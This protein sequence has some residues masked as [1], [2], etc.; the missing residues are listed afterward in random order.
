MTSI[1]FV[2][3]ANMLRSASAEYLARWLM[4][5]DS[6]NATDG[7]E[8]TSAGV[9]VLP[10]QPIYDDAAA[11]LSTRGIDASAHRARQLIGRMMPRATLILTFDSAQRSWALRESPGGIR[12]VLTIRRAANLLGAA[13]EPMPDGPSAGQ[14][15]TGRA[16]RR[17]GR[18]GL[19]SLLVD[20]APYGPDDDFADPVG[21]G[22][23]AVATAV[24]QIEELLRTILPAL[25]ARIVR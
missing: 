10:G 22:P 9:G 19:P 15:R 1:L 13:G 3:Q 24:D 23:R 20:R 16:R 2:C 11:A 17:S 8:F 12:S 21:T 5:T 25:G 18:P 14:P 7:W 4:G 6:H